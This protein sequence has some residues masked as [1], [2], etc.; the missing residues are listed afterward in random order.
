MVL[1]RT[2]LRKDS[3]AGSHFGS[4]RWVPVLVAILDLQKQ[5]WLLFTI[6]ISTSPGW[7][8]EADV[9]ELGPAGKHLFFSDEAMM[10]STATPLVLQV[11]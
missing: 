4:V 8:Y 10:I 2:L 9:I 1:D 3:V 7:M 6:T 11:G 5:A